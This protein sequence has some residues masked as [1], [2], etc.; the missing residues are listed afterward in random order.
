MRARFNPTVIRRISLVVA[1]VAGLTVGGL[2]YFRIKEK[3]DGLH[4]ELAAQTT[5]A[6]KAES[7]L[8]RSQKEMAAAAV[9]LKVFKA[10]L[11]QTTADKQ[12]AL[13]RATEQTALAEKQA[14]ELAV[15]HR[16][17]DEAQQSLARYV[18]AGLEPE[19]ILAAASEIRNLQKSLA[20]AEKR[21]GFLELQVKMLSSI[22]GEDNPVPLPADLKGTVISTDAK[23]R[24]LVLDVGASQGVLENGEVLLRRGDKLV[25]KARVS[26]VQPDRCVANMLT[27]WD[28][29]EIREGDVAIAATPQS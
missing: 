22:S 1:M 25:G 8:A 18:G 11:D 20:T 12:T 24:F 29:A 14:K 23:W 27:G 5:I 4:A 10:D 19:Q 7:D 16:K 15:T 13:A 21:V 17:L 2:N 28:F 9:R 6:Q 26:R 3:I